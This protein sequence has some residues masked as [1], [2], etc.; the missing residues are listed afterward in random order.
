MES[1]GLGSAGFCLRGHPDAVLPCQ[2]QERGLPGTGEGGGSS[3][4]SAFSE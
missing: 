2:V 1:Q 4:A 3:H